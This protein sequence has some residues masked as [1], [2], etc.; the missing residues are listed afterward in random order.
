[1]GRGKLSSKIFISY[2]RDDS[3]GH[4][5]R[6]H[7]RL[8]TTFGQDLL[9]MDVDAIPLG[10]NFADRLRSEVAKCDVLLAIIGP[11][12]RDVKD[13]SGSR[14]LDDPSDFVRIEIATALQ[15]G[16]PVIPVLLDNSAV[17][18][19]QD[20]PA[21]LKQLSLM[22]GLEVRH[23]SFHTDM[24]RLIRGLQPTTERFTRA[25]YQEPKGNY[26]YQEP[27]R[28]DYVNNGT[29]QA[30]DNRLTIALIWAIVPWLLLSVAHYVL[31]EWAE[32]ARHSGTMEATLIRLASLAPSILVGLILLGNWT[33]KLG[34][35]ALF[36][37]CIGTLLVTIGWTANF[38]DFLWHYSK[39]D[40]SVNQ[41]LGLILFFGV[42]LTYGV[43]HH[44]GE[45]Q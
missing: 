37:F 32:W 12:W 18:K 24:D 10:V 20:L 38:Y 17:P 21:D 29:G 28:N 2:R 23:A 25:E 40:Y 19:Q 4:A 5:G 27:I 26:E 31:I 7:D 11:N 14:R 15:R 3:A 6:V 36:F 30:S 35:G 44:N 43:I 9:F 1:M 33:T 13:A 34:S 8:Q 16:I 42:V 41:K 22:N 45:K 39:F